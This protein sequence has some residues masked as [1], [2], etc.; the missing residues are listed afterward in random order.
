MTTPPL[1]PVE[2]T[3]FE[4]SRFIARD[5]ISHHNTVEKAFTATEDECVALTK[6]FGVISLD[7]FTGKVQIAYIKGDK[8]Y[9]VSGNFTANVTQECR[10]T[11]KPIEQAIDE[12]F[13]ELLVTDKENLPSLEEARGSTKTIEFLDSDVID[14]GEI[15]TQWLSLALDPY[16]R[17]EGEVFEHIEH[18]PAE[19]NPFSALNSIKLQNNDKK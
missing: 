11:F 17:A 2:T 12:Q 8:N 19:T 7:S 14:Y 6:R 4:M 9:A 15:A 13:K 3:S 10:T 18:D 1:T 16:P 5:K